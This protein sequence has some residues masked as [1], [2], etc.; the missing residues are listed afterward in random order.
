MPLPATNI[1]TCLLARSKQIRSISS[2]F[3]TFFSLHSNQTK[4]QIKAQTLKIAVGVAAGFEG[5]VVVVVVVVVVGV[6][7]VGSW[8]EGPNWD[9]GLGMNENREQRN[10][11]AQNKEN[12]W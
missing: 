6:A 9:R 11:K 5:V 10:E 12:R 4:R 3:P 1:A 2:V 8:G 7:A